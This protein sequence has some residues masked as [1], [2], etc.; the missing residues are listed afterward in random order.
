M[1]LQIESKFGKQL[2]IA[3]EERGQRDYVHFVIMKN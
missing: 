2:I 1:H 3:K